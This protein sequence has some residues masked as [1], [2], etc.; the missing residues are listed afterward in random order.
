[1]NTLELRGVQVGGG[2]ADLR[3]HRCDH[4]A[5]VEILEADGVEIVLEDEAND[6]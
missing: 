1:V 3:F 5:D 2:S 6:G 4:G